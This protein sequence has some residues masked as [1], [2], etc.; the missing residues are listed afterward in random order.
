MIFVT[1]LDSTLVLYCRA[2]MGQRKRSWNLI[3]S[4]KVYISLEGREEMSLV[5]RCCGINYKMLYGVA[6]T[7]ALM[8][9]DC[10]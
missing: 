2:T 5:K 7:H 6:T 10:A 9:Y 1:S 8:S 4:G 3:Q